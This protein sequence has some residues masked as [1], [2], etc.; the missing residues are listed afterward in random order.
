MIT[1]ELTEDQLSIQDMARKFAEREIRPIAEKLDRS[2][3]LLD[4]FPWSLVQKGSEVGFR[5]AALPIEYDGPGF[6]YRTWVV[7]IDE[8][9]YPDAACAQIFSQNWKLC[10]AIARRGTKEQKDRFL[11]IFRDDDRFLL[12]GDGA[13]P[14]HLLSPKP[15]S[16]TPGT[17]GTLAATCVGDQYVLNG[18]KRFISFGP[19]AK[20]LLVNAHT[21]K[22]SMPSTFLV[23]AD[24]P[25]C[26]LSCVRDKV[27]FRMHLHGEFEFSDVKIPAENL[28]G[29]KEAL[30]DDNTIAAASSLECAAYAMALSR[31][32]I[33]AAT[34]YATER[35]QGGK[36]IIEHQAV[37][38]ALADMYVHLQAGRSLLWRVAWTMDND[39]IDPALT[40][41]CKVL[42][43]EAAVRICRDAVELFGGSGVMRELPL[44]KYFR[45][46]LVLL[47][48]GGTNHGHR[49]K[50]DAILASRAAQGRFSR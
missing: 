13:D 50:I 23:P 29:G 2:Q 37:A 30:P 34:K 33:D 6:D 43:T 41:A 9:A 7:L 20:L 31:A 48:I 36:R 25:G 38:L 28:L 15:A 1:F 19:G 26:S 24:T 44:Q 10:A 21:D 49:S 47:H 5:T 40:L 12:G 4:D 32:A 45:D 14:Q 17:S 46:S 39:R 22:E 35:I 18:R 11:P 42:C 16:A 27:G 8:L 3:H